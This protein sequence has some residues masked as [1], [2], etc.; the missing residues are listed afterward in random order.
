MNETGGEET[1]YKRNGVDHSD[2]MKMI[3]EDKSPQSNLDKILGI[4][5]VKKDGSFANAT[6]N[7]TESKE[8]ITKSETSFQFSM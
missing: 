1:S 3:V 7:R 8:G 2:Q 4:D 6:V 5:W